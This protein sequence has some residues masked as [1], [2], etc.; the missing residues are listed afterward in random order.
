MRVHGFGVGHGHDVS[1]SVLWEGVSVLLVRVFRIW[2]LWKKFAV[3][4]VSSFSFLFF[5]CSFLVMGGV[6]SI[7]GG[8]RVFKRR[9]ITL[10]E[11]EGISMAKL[12]Q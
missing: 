4:F 6:D 7:Y 5:P 2:P 11:L 10:G 3:F 12:V 8:K 9:Y 1:Q